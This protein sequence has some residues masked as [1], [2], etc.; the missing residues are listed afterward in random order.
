MT[1][2]ELIKALDQLRATMISV[3]TGGPRIQQVQAEFQ[4]NCDLV[5]VEL[6]NREPVPEI[7]TGR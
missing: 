7:C 4:E 6:T 3:A 2:A 5:D 1:N